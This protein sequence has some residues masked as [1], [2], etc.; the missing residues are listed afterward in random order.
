M[1]W[2]SDGDQRCFNKAPGAGGASR[3]KGRNPGGQL[4]GR[5]ALGLQ[6]EERMCNHGEEE[7]GENVMEMEGN[8][9]KNSERE[10]EKQ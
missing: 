2:G 1:K 7:E 9:G 8:R 6:N 3:I 5:G 10:R 4:P